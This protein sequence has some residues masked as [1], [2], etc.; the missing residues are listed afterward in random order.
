ME[1]DGSKLK[2]AYNMFV[3]ANILHSMINRIELWANGRVIKNLFL[4]AYMAHSQML[5]FCDRGYIDNVL[6]TL[7]GFAKDVG[8]AEDTSALNPGASYR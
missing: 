1:A 3:I 7:T 6:K 5:L 4:Y 8:D 2:K